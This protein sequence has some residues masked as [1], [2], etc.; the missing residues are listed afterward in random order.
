M[1][2]R[3]ALLLQA[4]VGG[5]GPATLVQSQMTQS[6]TMTWPSTPTNGNLLLVIASSSNDP[7]TYASLSALGYTLDYSAFGSAASRYT[8]V[9]SKVASGDPGSITATELTAGGRMI[10]GFEFSGASGYSFD[11]G[12]NDNSGTPTVTTMSVTTAALRRSPSIAI[13][14]LVVNNSITDQD[15]GSPWVLA[16]G[17]LPASAAGAYLIPTG[18]SAL[19]QTWGWTTARRAVAAIAVYN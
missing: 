2:R 7:A 5:G 3:R 14:A 4:A 12:A 8:S 15:P 11:T 18:T 1:S 13:A 9:W 16:A 10:A 17:T 6:Q 19:S